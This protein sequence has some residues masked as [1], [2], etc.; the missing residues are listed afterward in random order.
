MVT[1]AVE[2]VEQ[3]LDIGEV[4]AGGRLVEN[5]QRLASISL[6]QFTGQL[7]PLRLAAG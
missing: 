1:Q 2:H 3:L 6:G 4:Q 5:V 7:D